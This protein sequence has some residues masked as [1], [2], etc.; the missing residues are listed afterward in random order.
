MAFGVRMAIPDLSPESHLK[1]REL[2]EPTGKYIFAFGPP[3]NLG[4]QLPKRLIYCAGIDLSRKGEYLRVKPP[5]LAHVCKVAE[6]KS[7]QDPV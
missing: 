2:N 4:Q 3:V 1:G 6:I 5:D 7:I